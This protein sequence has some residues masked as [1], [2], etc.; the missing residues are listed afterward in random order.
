MVQIEQF[1]Q[2][3]NA[4]LTRFING[5]LRNYLWDCENVNQTIRHITTDFANRVYPDSTAAFNDL[6]SKAILLLDML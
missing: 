3:M 5:K 2:A 6:K 1:A 4:A